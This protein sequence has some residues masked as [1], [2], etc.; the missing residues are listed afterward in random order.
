VFVAAT[1]RCFPE[2][3]L[4]AAMMQL[5]DLEYTCVEIIIHESGGHLRP[6][7]VMADVEKAI[8]HCRQMHRLTPAAFSVDIEA[9]ENL[10]YKQFAACCKLAKAVKVVTITVRA[11]ELG[12]PFNAEVE[13]LRELV[14]ISSGDGIRVG[15]LTEAGRMTQDPN[16]AMV[17]CDNVKGLGISLDPSHYVFGPQAGANYEH[18]LKYV[19][20]VRL[21]DTNKTSLQ[22]RVGQGEVEY[23]RLV[24][25]LHKCRYDRALCVDIAPLPDVDHLAEMRKMRLLLE[26]LL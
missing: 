17:L 13:R 2:L 8:L 6:S 9:P 10:Y 21:R 22:V 12:T 4:D 18:L 19:Y 11:G 14:A 20:H 3:S 26:S 16:T 5:A 25:Q 7:A 24:N 15:L 23:G 1:S